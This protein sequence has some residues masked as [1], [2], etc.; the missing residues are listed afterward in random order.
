MMRR[1]VAQL[2]TDVQESSWTIE[3]IAARLDKAPSTLYSM[4]NPFCSTTHKLGLEEAMAIA[5]LVSATR[6]LELIAHDFGFTLTDPQ[7]DKPD[8]S[9]MRE[10]VLQGYQ[11]THDFLCAVD[12]GESS[13]QLAMKCNRAKKELNDVAQRKKNEEQRLHA[14]K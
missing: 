12:E 4:L 3:Q 7:Y 5:R 9:D 1:Y 6:F 14:V 10:E 2:Q 11:A 8:A 13:S